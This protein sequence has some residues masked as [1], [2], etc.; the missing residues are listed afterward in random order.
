LG[1]DLS[2]PLQGPSSELSCERTERI[3]VSDFIYIAGVSINDFLLVDISLCSSVIVEFNKHKLLFVNR[4]SS[5][6]IP[7]I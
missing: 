3:L 2:D 1:A 5:T 7:A 4:K 6:K